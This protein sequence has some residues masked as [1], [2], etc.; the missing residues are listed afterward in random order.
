MD[1]ADKMMSISTLPFRF[2]LQAVKQSLEKLSDHENFPWSGALLP[3]SELWY[4]NTEFKN[5]L[6]GQ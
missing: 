1:E 6:F 3:I 4:L 5:S 2:S